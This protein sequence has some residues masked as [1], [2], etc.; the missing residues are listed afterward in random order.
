MFM[1]NY[2]LHRLTVFISV[3]SLAL[4]QITPVAGNSQKSLITVEENGKKELRGGVWFILKAV[5]FVG[6]EK[7]DQEELKQFYQD[8]IGKSATSFDLSEISMQI[9]DFYRHSLGLQTAV[10]LPS[11]RINDGVVKIRIFEEIA[12]PEERAA[13]EAASRIARIAVDGGDMLSVDT[14]SPE[15]T[16][17]TL[18]EKGGKELSGDVSFI[19]KSVKFEVREP[20]IY[21]EALSKYYQ[22]KIENKV[23][24]ADLEE[25]VA[26]VKKHYE[27]KRKSRPLLA[28][29]LPSQHISDGV[30]KI[31]LGKPTL[32]GM[33]VQMPDGSWQAVR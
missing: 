31:K 6:E 17:I 33:V 3:L 4:L 32:D 14:K 7:F 24:L 19:L 2:L 25:I 15:K 1:F 13:A 18:G 10:A 23:T 26:N 16:V 9:S 27:T 12:N 20:V 8:K 11:Q 29:T 30:V 21:D 5:E 22:E 28:A